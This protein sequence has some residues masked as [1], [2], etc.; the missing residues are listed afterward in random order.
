MLVAI[1][2][3]LPNIL[4]EYLT[5]IHDNFNLAI[6]YQQI[7]VLVEHTHV[8]HEDLDMVKQGE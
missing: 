4:E 1:L 5:T 2:L 3:P 7:C 8:M 6:I